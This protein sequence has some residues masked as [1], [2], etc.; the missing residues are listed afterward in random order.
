[1]YLGKPI[2]ASKVGG[3]PEIVI[4]GE[5]GLLFESQNYNELAEKIIFLIKNPDLLE[6]MGE[7]SKNLVRKKEFSA[8]GMVEKIEELYEKSISKKHSAFSF[9]CKD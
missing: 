6:K 2:I 9:M 3:I 5:N 4:D 7:N 8:E 1:M